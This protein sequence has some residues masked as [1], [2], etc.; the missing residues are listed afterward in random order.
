MLHVNIFLY[1][2]ESFSLSCSNNER[3]DY[4]PPC[5]SEARQGRGNLPVQ[6]YFFV[7]TPMNE[8]SSYQ[9][10]ATSLRSSQ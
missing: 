3:G 4:R 9:E 6:G 2:I 7:R 1:R 8:V 5:H 10:I